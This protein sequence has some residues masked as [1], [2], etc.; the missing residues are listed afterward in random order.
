MV[1][2]APW[3]R[4]KRAS[5]R[6]EERGRGFIIMGKGERGTEKGERRNEAATVTTVVAVF[7]KLPGSPGVHV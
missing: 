2:V 1:V 3:Y 6:E 5:E 4:V 7:A